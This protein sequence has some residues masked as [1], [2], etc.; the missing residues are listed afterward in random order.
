VEW[1]QRLRLA[2][3]RNRALVF[4]TPVRLVMLGAWLGQPLNPMLRPENIRMLV[5]GYHGDS[6]PW[7]EFLGRPAMEFSP[8]LLHADAQQALAQMGWQS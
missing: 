6:R 5:K 4:R 1:L 2:Q 3:G 7:R 8:A